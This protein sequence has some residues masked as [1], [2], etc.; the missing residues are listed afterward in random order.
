VKD[1]HPHGLPQPIGLRRASPRILGV[2]ARNRFMIQPEKL[3]GEQDDFDAV[4]VKL[5]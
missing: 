1:M 2:E 4:S 3:S 5:L